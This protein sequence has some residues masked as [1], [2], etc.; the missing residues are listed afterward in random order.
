MAKFRK[1]KHG[2][3]HRQV[4]AYTD[5]SGNTG[6]NLFDPSQPYFWT[7]TLL[8]YLDIDATS[9]DKHRTWTDAL[10]VNELHGN[11]LGIGKINKIAESI[12]SFLENQQARFVFTQI[13]K[14]YHAVATLS[15]IILDSDYN[16]AVSFLH[17]LASVFHRKMS[18]DI[19][20]FLTYGE[21]KRF[22][23]AYE[24]CNLPGFVKILDN[25]ALRI[26]EGHPDKRGRQLLLDALAY[27]VCNAKDVFR[28]K[29]SDQDSPNL[30]ALDLLLAGIHKVT[31][32]RSK[33]VMFRHDE[34]KQ[35]G[36]AMSAQFNMAKNVRGYA[37]P[38]TFMFRLERVERFACPI[39][40]VPSHTSIGLQIIDLGIYLASQYLMGTYRPREDHCSALTEYIIN[41]ASLQVF[42]FDG[43]VDTYTK[44]YETIMEKEFS[45]EDLTRAEEMRDIVEM[46]RV[47]RMELSD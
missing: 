12:L 35:F 36:S 29:R 31:D 6:H 44:D 43:L 8:T 30:L 2:I 26:Y 18:L 21:A 11:E 4:F 33:V 28:K 37:E 34:Q 23:S 17:D 27:A 41:N 22:W 14:Q 16:K 10:R 20:A 13:E 19:F 46:R 39:S 1:D 45:P 5:E 38:D 47:R 40:L 9:W 42:T 3:V 32:E 15:F 7:G 24:T 25:L